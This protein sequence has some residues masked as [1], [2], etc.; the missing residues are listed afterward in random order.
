M[1]NVKTLFGAV[2]LLLSPAVA[3][4]ESVE[5]VR[6]SQPKAEA[7]APTN[8]IVTPSTGKAKAGKRKNGQFVQ[9]EGAPAGG[10]A[11]AGAGG[12]VAGGGGGFLGGGLGAIAGVTVA[13]GVG[14][15]VGNEINGGAPASP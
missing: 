2:V 5:T 10:A 4:A 12:A 9:V 7:A 8:K 15:I 3:S 14:A 6:P 1:A 11:P 13:S